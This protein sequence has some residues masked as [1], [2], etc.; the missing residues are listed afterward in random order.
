MI[1]YG[2]HPSRKPI[3]LNREMTEGARATQSVDVDGAVELK[4]KSEPLPTATLAVGETFRWI[5]LCRSLKS[6]FGGSDVELFTVSQDAQFVY[7]SKP[8]DLRPIQITR[9]A[10]TRLGASKT[11]VFLPEL[12]HSFSSEN[13]MNGD[14]RSFVA[15]LDFGIDGQ[16]AIRIS[17]P[18]GSP[19][20]SADDLHKLNR[21]AS[22][23]EQE[24]QTTRRILTSAV[25]AY[26]SAL[27]YANR[28]FALVDESLQ[29][30]RSNEHFQRVSTSYFH[31]AAGALVPSNSFET[32]RIREAIG[33]ALSG[34]SK[35][36]VS[37]RRENQ[38]CVA[39][40]HKVRLA[41]LLVSNRSLIGLELKGALPP[42]MADSKLLAELFGL[43]RREADVAALLSSGKSVTSIAKL[44]DVSVG[45]V[46]VQLKAIFRKTGV[47]GQVELISKVLAFRF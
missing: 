28:P 29:V 7:S 2:R 42:A 43:T 12:P 21:C 18:I 46:R 44:H 15:S 47:A 14:S 32:K 22:S 35:A 40:L 27:Q 38:S 24:A 6:E 23:L 34:H 5:E 20:F 33:D 3:Y 1:S 19:A 41:H 10:Q 36:E 45:T 9:E 13:S 11:V 37:L 39:V 31:F 8:I 16:Y 17:R 4:E 25:E 30:L 26:G